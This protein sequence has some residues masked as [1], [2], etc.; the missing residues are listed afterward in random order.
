MARDGAVGLL[1]AAGPLGQLDQARVQEHA[2][3]EVEVARVDAQPLGELPVRHLLGVV[4]GSERLEHAQPQR[5]P[6]RL[7]LVGAADRQRLA[8]GV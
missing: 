6:E 5:M 2:H 3:V 8:H 4:V 7:Q 1:A